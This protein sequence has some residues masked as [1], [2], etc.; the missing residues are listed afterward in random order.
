MDASKHDKIFRNVK[1]PS[2]LSKSHFQTGCQLVING[3]NYCYF[4]D[5]EVHAM[6]HCEN[7]LKGDWKCKGDRNFRGIGGVR[8]IDILRG[9]EV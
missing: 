5:H 1:T 8:G 2:I 6:D 3:C 4:H 7:L 9:L